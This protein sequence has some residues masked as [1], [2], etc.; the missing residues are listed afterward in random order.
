VLYDTVEGRV[1]PSTDKVQY[2]FY[3]IETTQNTEYTDEAKLKVPNFVCV[4]QFCSRCEDVE[5]VERDCVR[6][7]KRNHSFRQDLVGELLTYL[8]EPRPCAN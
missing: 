6:C 7:V 1:H 4:L 8:T 2:V 5:G 3:D